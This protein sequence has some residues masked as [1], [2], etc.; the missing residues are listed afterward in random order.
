MS[1]PRTSSA[2]AHH[3]MSSAAAKETAH[4]RRPGFASTIPGR[5]AFAGVLE[6]TVRPLSRNRYPG[7]ARLG[8]PVRRKSHAARK[9]DNEKALAVVALESEQYGSIRLRSSLLPD[10][11]LSLFGPLTELNMPTAPPL[12]DSSRLHG[13]IV[14]GCANAG[15]TSLV[16][17]LLAVASGAYASRFDRDLEAKR[18]ARMTMY[19]QS[20][21][22]AGGARPVLVDGGISKQM[23]VFLTDLPSLVAGTG[24]STSPARVD[25]GQ[26]GV[27]LTAA[28]VYGTGGV[29]ASCGCGGATSAAVALDNCSPAVGD[30]AGGTTASIASGRTTVRPP[31][32]S[33]IFVVDATEPPLWEDT[34][35]QDIAQLMM[36]FRQQNFPVV[37]AVTKLDSARKRL[38]S[39]GHNVHSTYEAHADWYLEGVCGAIRRAAGMS[40]GGPGPDRPTD[41]FP[42]PNASCFDAPTWTKV[43]EWRACQERRASRGGDE[44]GWVYYQSQLRRLLVAA[45]SAGHGPLAYARPQQYLASFCGGGPSRREPLRAHF[46]WSEQ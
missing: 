39:L 18:R 20:Y 30:L 29:E 36:R 22:V 42:I 12:E 44:P 3:V 38:V 23:R 27:V 46:G 7:S 31:H 11:R 34:R 35:C 28:A 24:T 43:G 32:R 19:G 2:T 15:K 33:V 13:I 26:A 25:D 16:F 41:V 4:H 37:I 14:V 17:S 8:S 9:E 5:L 10:T 6:D 1:R 40:C 21:E 45:Q